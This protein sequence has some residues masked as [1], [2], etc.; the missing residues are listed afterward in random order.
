MIKFQS[1]FVE[2][3]PGDTEFDNYPRQVSNSCYSYAI[4]KPAIDPNLVAFSKDCA[5]LID[6]EPESSQSHF[7]I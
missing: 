3:L 4:P 1:D 5:R 6:I 2:K 7:S